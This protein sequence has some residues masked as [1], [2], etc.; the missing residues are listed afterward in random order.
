MQNIKK[1]NM[2]KALKK[3]ANKLK[4]KKQIKTV[5]LP[6]TK[7]Y[8][9]HPYYKTLIDPSSSSTCRVPGQFA[10]KTVLLHRHVT[11]AT[12]TNVLGRMAVLWQP[13][14]LFDN[15]AASSLLYICNSPTYDGATVFPNYTNTLVNYSIPVGNVLGYRL[16]SAEMRIQTQENAQNISG[17]IG[18]ALAPV[19]AITPGTPEGTSGYG[20]VSVIQNYEAYAE[21][22]L[23]S[24]ESAKC[25]WLPNDIHDYEIYLMDQDAA[26]QQVQ[27]STILAYVTGTTVAGGTIG[28]VPINLEI[29]LNYE[30]Q[31]QAGSILQGMGEISYDKTNPSDIVYEIRCRPELICYAYVNDNDSHY[32]MTSISQ[33]IPTIKAIQAKQVESGW[34][35]PVRWV[36]GKKK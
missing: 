14:S 32:H 16:V 7:N 21:A 36:N 34:E 5:M 8:V 25:I 9:N 15:S 29:Y 17:K 30:L 19:A 2:S 31:P 20:T 35:T 1:P 13:T 24:K 12:S 11:I 28:S 4:L 3:V 10:T 27:E 23:C 18:I 6:V 26:A 33:D 22:D